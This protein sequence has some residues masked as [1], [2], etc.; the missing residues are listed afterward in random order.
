MPAAMSPV[1][2]IIPGSILCSD[3]DKSSSA[4]VRDTDLDNTPSHVIQDDTLRF[5][6]EV[7]RCCSWGS[8]AIIFYRCPSNYVSI[9]ACA[10]G[11]IINIIHTKPLSA[12]DLTTRMKSTY[13]PPMARSPSP[14]QEPVGEK[15]KKPTTPNH[16]TPSIMLIPE[17]PTAE[18]PTFRESLWAIFCCS[19]MFRH[20]RVSACGYWPPARLEYYAYLHSCSSKWLRGPIFGVGSAL[21]GNELH[22]GFSILFSLKQWE[23]EMRLFSYVSTLT[24]VEST[25]TTVLR[26]FLSLQSF[27]WQRSVLC[28][29]MEPDSWLNLVLRHR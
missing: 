12:S 8:R 1:I 5:W 18:G 17:R 7:L 11:N 14:R 22:S 10:R 3:R 4:T 23:T 16:S 19:C 6:S 20:C 21:T 2:M 13:L 15:V 24:N 26:Q 9:G 29:R 25:L 27:L 28:S